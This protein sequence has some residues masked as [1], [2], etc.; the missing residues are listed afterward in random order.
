MQGEATL[1]LLY[2]ADK[3][4]QKLPRIVKGAIYEFQHK[5]R[6][7][8]DAPGLQ[9]KRLQGDSRLFSARVTSDYRAL[10]LHV[11]DRDYVLVAVRHRRDVYDN[12]ERYRYQINEVTGAIE[13]VDLVT[14][15]QS[16]ASPPPPPPEP[17]RAP[18]APEPLF[19][20]FTD[21]QL[22]DLGVAAP[23][24]PLIRKITTEEELLGLCEYAPAHTTEV[25]LALYEG[26]SYEEVLE[27]IT[28]PVSPDEE[29]DTEDYT[30]ALARPATRVTTED[31]DLQ[32]VIEGEFA[33]WKVFLHPTQR[34]LVERSY[35]GPARV[36][37]GPGTGKTIVALHRVKHLVDRLPPGDDKPVLLTTFNVNLA[38]DLRKRLL[39][40]GGPETVARVDIVNIDKLATKIVTESEPGGRRRWIDDAKAL[41]EWRAM[42]TELGETRWD[43]EFLHAEWTHIILGH[44]I[45]SRTDY[46]RVRRAGRGRTIG[47]AQRAEIWRLVEKF[48]LRLDEKNLW[49][50]RQVAE[51]AARLEIAR[52]AKIRAYQESAG[53]IHMADTSAAL[54]RHRYRHAVVDEAQDLSAAHWKMLRAMVPEGPDDL[55]IVGD[56]HQRIYDNVVSLGSLGIN[57]RGRSARLT[58][59]YRTTHE[60]LGHALGLLGEE[61]WDDLDDGTDDLNGYRSLLRGPRPVF[62][63][64]GTWEEELDHIAEHVAALIDGPAPSIAVCVPERHMVP[65]VEGRLARAGIPAA[66][67]GSDGPRLDDVV[68]VGTMHRFKGLE[69]QHMIIAGVDADHIP[70]AYVRQYEHTDPARHRRELQRA[71]SLIFVAATRARDT[72]LITW[73]GA[74]SPFLPAR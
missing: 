29:I 66:A 74:P 33:K 28:R 55:F 35:N 62:R 11:G 36:S 26:C 16:L 18:A 37:G 15:E 20:A 69:Y 9:L 65:A 60:I 53:N 12:L 72:L 73:T 68:H 61:S 7:N 34:R 49:T 64:F 14:A 58:L 13:F 54:M 70:P 59:S 23:L 45:N 67:I 2:Q 44:A 63:G 10:L 21:G 25:L 40:L 41:D 3:E 8:P 6:K 42:L 5:F 31:T 30:A 38:A 39:D 52:L 48:V 17:I 47:R 1:R 46:F 71:R 32:Q 24:L 43:A 56:T 19:A 57:I 51:R 50:Y 4:I 22:L 27:E